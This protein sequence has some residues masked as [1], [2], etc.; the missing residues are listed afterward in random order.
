[1]T[2]GEICRF[3]DSFADPRWAES[4]DNVGL[5]VGR[6]EKEVSEVL[7]SLDVTEQVV[8]EA[9][10]SGCQLIVAHHPLIFKPLK[11]ISSNH[12]TERTVMMAIENGVAIYATHTNLDNA[13]WGVNRRIGEV[14]GLEK[15]KIL[16]PFVGRLKKL[17]TYVPNDHLDQVRDALF[18]AGAGRIGHYD[19]CS[20]TVEGKGTYKPDE[21][22][23]PYSG[24]KGKR[25]VEVETRLEVLVKDTDSGQVVRRLFEAHPYEEVAYELISLSNADQ[26]RGAGM[27]GE[28]KEPIAT[29]DFI[30]S[31]KSKFKIPVIRH[32]QPNQ[33]HIQKIA[34]CGGSGI[35]LLKDAISAGAD[36]F[37][38]GD[39]KYHDF[40]EADNQLLLADI[41]HFEG[42]QFT[43]DLLVENLR[44]FTTFAVRL[45]E[46]STNPILYA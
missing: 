4:Y 40:F 25:S 46:S 33:E 18:D 36:V 37:L 8:Q 22:S 32:T 30:E 38:T 13:A 42:E 6:P 28:L 1:M 11:R 26:D 12:W 17:V 15:M 43:R 29:Q 41:G 27:I 5:L 2:V 7:V 20:F 39:I 9:I 45:A 16:R 10:D 44:S 23:T 34:F 19:E 14:L 31:L 3:L 35:F 24:E 21:Q